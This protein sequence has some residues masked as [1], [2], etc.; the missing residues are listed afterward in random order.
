MI[1]EDERDTYTHNAD[2][3]EFM[4]D[5]PQGQPEGISGLNNEFEYYADR[6]I[7]INRY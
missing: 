2:G 4:G 1:V 7:D 3:R 5:R 6:I